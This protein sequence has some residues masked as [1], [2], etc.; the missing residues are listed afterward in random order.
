M[1]IVT[2]APDGGMFDHALCEEPTGDTAL[3]EADV[4]CSDCAYG[5]EQADEALIAR[6]KRRGFR[7]DWHM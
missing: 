4:T 3:C 6:L 7:F 5:V 2:H 1:A